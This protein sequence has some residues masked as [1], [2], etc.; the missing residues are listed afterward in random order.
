MATTYTVKWGDTLSAIAV[1]YNT[2]VNALVKLNN[3][4]DPDFIV[5]GQVLKLSGTAEPVVKNT[6]SK[7]KIDRFGLQ[8]NTDR[9]VYATWTWD[10]ANT[11]SYRVYWE[12]NTGDK[13]WFVGNDSNVT[14]KQSSY[15]APNNAI[16]VRFKVLP[17]SK[18]HDVNGK[19]VAYWTNA[20]WS[21][22]KK[23]DFSSNPPKGPSSP[24]EVTITGTKLT[25]NISNLGGLNAT[26]VQFDIAKDNIPS[27]K[28]SK[29]PI[30]KTDSASYECTVDLGS[31]YKV[32]CRTC[33]NE[34]YSDWTA[35]S[36]EYSTVP[37]APSEITQCTTGS[38]NQS[39][40]LKW[41]EVTNATSYDIEYTTTKSF[42]EAPSSNE[43]QSITGVTTAA[44]TITGIDAGKEYFVRVRAVNSIG[45]SEWTAISSTAVG[46]TAAAPTTWSS[47][48]TVVVGDPLTLY[49]LHN[50]EDGSSPTYADLELYVNSVKKVVPTFDYTGSDGST[51]QTNEVKTHTIDTTEYDEGAKLQWRVRTAGATKTFGDWSVLRTVDVYAQPE[52]EVLI[53]DAAGVTHSSANSSS[54]TID[55]Y[56]LNIEAFARPDLQSAIGYHVTVTANESYETVDNVGNLDIINE[57]EVIYSQHFDTLSS[58]APNAFSLVLSAG[59]VNLMDGINYTITCTVTMNSG[60]SAEASL[61][62]TP[63]WADTAY[64]VDAEIGI[65]TDDYTASIRPYCEDANGALV[66]DILLYVYRREFDGSFT[67]LAVD[68]PNENST[69]ITDPHPSLDY[70]RYRIVAMNTKTGA[71]SYSD[72]P[73]YYVGC[74]AVIVQ[75]DEQWTDFD[76]VSTP[77]TQPTWSGSLLKLP[78]NVDVSDKYAIDVEL[79]EYIGREHPVSYYGTQLGESS[80]WNVAIPKSDK[81]TLY[82]LRRLARWM[83]NVYVREPSGSGY[84]ANV[85]VSFSQKHMEVTIPVTMEITRVEG[86]A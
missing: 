55:S 8:T 50:S 53:T 39:I 69:Y 63:L 19:S 18:T 33:R 5:V 41:T 12:Y 82:S 71:I 80:T 43:P 30:S 24:P 57:N 21:D 67:E 60:L 47:T 9:T 38:D 52:I 32:R 59:D 45:A 37:S 58:T 42:F 56:P 76:P 62:F 70:A 35:W 16:S 31:K 2:T 77:T 14:V 73:G 66:E 79:V 22:S 65:D 68:I 49:W 20:K 23:Y 7:A 10:K 11:D 40:V 86:G 17:I 28:G 54:F 61:Y 6:S 27:F 44:Y 84:W 85:K 1:R 75:W 51:S 15:N 83:G 25:T 81:E 4:A 46:T 36:N 34:V 29:V 3:I 48:T 13:V 26:I 72:I 74:K 64:T 78:Y